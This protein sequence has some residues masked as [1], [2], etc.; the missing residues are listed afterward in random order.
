MLHLNKKNLVF[1]DLTDNS[2]EVNPWECPNW[3]I[4]ALVNAETILNIDL[5]ICILVQIA[6][7]ASQAD[8]AQTL[9]QQ[10]HT[11]DNRSATA[12]QGKTVVLSQNAEESN[13]RFPEREMANGN[14]GKILITTKIFTTL[15]SS[16]SRTEAAGL[17]EEPRELT[18]Q[19]PFND[20][21]NVESCTLIHSV[22]YQ[23]R[24]FWP[25][26]IW[27]SKASGSRSLW[28]SAC[29]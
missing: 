16:L 3:I 2:P 26:M 19:Q 22:I 9:K 12:L 25:A 23:D 24:G 11:V 17:E 20:A 7:P 14:K 15:Y 10:L 4:N 6:G 18:S 1:S 29:W 5:Q 8:S 21:K 13:Q 28:W 27:F